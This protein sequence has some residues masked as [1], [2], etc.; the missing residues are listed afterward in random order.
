MSKHTRE[1]RAIC[2]AA[3]LTVLGIDMRRRH[4]VVRCVEGSVVM[5]STPSDH[6]WRLNARCV[7][8]RLARSFRNSL[9]TDMV[10]HSGIDRVNCRSQACAARLFV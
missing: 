8:R 4:P 1:C 6:R 5:P 7:A 3:G 10:R 9:T 2:E